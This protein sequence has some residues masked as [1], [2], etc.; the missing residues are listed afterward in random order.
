[1][2]KKTHTQRIGKMNSMSIV[3]LLTMAV[4]GGVI[5]FYI[6]QSV[7]ATQTLK[8]LTTAEEFNVVQQMEA[9]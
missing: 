2:A 6:G 7:G 9:K 3:I 4:F 5:G 8:A 1:M